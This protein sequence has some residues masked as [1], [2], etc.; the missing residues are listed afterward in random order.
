MIYGWPLR[1]VAQLLDCY[2]FVFQLKAYSQ[3]GSLLMWMKK[4]LKMF[5]AI[6]AQLSQLALAIM[7]KQNQFELKHESLINV[8]GMYESVSLMRKSLK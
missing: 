3:L 4:L 1:N 2:C 7:G 5:N 6:I 8:S